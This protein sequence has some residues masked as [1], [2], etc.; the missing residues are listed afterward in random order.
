MEKRKL[1]FPLVSVIIPA[2]NAE[3][4]LRN[5]IDSVINQSYPNIE[6]IVVNDGSKD[7]TEKIALSYGN[8]VRY[9]FQKN[10][11]VSSALNRGI[12]ESK[13]DYIAWLS[14][15]D[16]F[17]PSK[18]EKQIDSFKLNPKAHICYTD[19]NV[20]DDFGIHQGVMKLPYYSKEDFSF[21]LLQA[22]FVCGST[23]LI[24]KTC[25]FKENLFFSED[26][27]YAQ[28]ADL[29]MKLSLKYNYIHIDECLVN[30]RF[31][32]EQ[33]SRNDSAMRIDKRRYLKNAVNFIGVKGFFSDD[34]NIRNFEAL[35][36]SKLAYTMLKCH[37]EPNL[38]IS[39]Y[40][41]SILYWPSIMNKSIYRLIALLL[42][43]QFYY[44]IGV[45]VARSLRNLKK[46]RLK[47]PNVDFK[48]AS[49]LVDK[50]FF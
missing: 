40:F 27:K 37:R 21:H 3:N 36:F 9:F 17:L 41:K 2:Y 25:F 14:H 26:L 45:L 43:S 28:D 24:K 35:A 22:M 7:N 34:Q 42:F 23:V 4:F 33:G 12:N 5:S 20:I 46:D 48:K 6:L 47:S 30:W 29:W 10:S 1:E 11:G 50:T 15:D 16:C 31:H 39:L 8:K 38:A 44:K 19:Y 13:G 18:I 49:C 32:L